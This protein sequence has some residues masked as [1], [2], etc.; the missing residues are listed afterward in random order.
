VRNVKLFLLP[1]LPLGIAQGWL[2]KE[3]IDFMEDELSL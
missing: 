3:E 2:L 1:N